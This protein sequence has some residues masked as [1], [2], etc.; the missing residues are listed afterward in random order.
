MNREIIFIGND[1]RIF[2]LVRYFWIIIAFVLSLMMSSCK[3]LVEIPPPTS[4]LSE[5]SVFTTDATA[6]PV[7]TGIYS[8]INQNNQPFQGVN[9]ISMYTGLSGDELRLIGGASYIFNL[10]YSN[11][12]SV[13]SGNIAGA[14]LWLPLYKLIYRTNAAIEGLESSK[15]LTPAVKNQL[16]GEAKFLRG[17]FYFYLVNLFGEVPLA[18]VTDPKVNSLLSKSSVD[19]VY[20]QILIDL[21]DAESLLSDSYFKD[22]LLIPGTER[23]RPTKWVATALIARI[24]LYR[25]NFDKADEKATSLINNSTLFGLVALND[26]FLKNSREAIWQ[27]QPTVVNFNTVEAQTFIFSPTGLLTA[28]PAYL[29]TFQLNSFES[30]DKRA[31]VGNWISSR[32]IAGNTYFFPFKYKLGD[33]DTTITSTSNMKEYFMM[34]RLAEQYLIRAEAKAK[35]GD[36][37]GAQSDINAIRTRAGLSNTTANSEQTLLDAILKERQ[38]E[39]FCE[40]G[41]RW[42]DLKRTGKIDELM[43]IITPIK[44][45]GSLWQSYQ[46]LYPIRQEDIEANPNLIQNIGY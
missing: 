1:I 25:G 44:S 46:K 45:N 31:V 16:L 9:G 3:K 34:F 38:V 22:G 33:R 24:Y 23:T 15:E 28:R 42:M 39:L 7:L 32:T 43:D 6:I 27:L 4:A 41:H 14:E 36:I 11:Q 8:T 17:Y 40:L 21:N 19:E 5:N 37:I 29:T 13:S 26:V 20:E 35:R 10:Y 18:L 2:F 30:N 12:L